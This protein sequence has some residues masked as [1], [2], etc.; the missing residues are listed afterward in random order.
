[1][2]Y[3]ILAAGSTTV[4]GDQLVKIVCTNLGH[5]DADMVVFLYDSDVVLFKP[6]VI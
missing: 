1:M 4:R 5:G 6:S 2:L 3:Y